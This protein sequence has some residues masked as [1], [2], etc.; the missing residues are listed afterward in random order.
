MTTWQA[1]F[2]RRPLQDELGNPLWELVVCTAD[3]SFT[4]SAFCP[5]PEANS[6]WISQ[7]LQRLIEGNINRSPTQIQVFRPQSVSLLQAACQPLNITVIPTRNTAALKALLQEKAELYRTLPH[8]TGQSYEPVA[9]E[10]P[11]PLPLPENLWGETWRFATI[12]AQDLVSAF[13][14]R[15]IPVLEMPEALLPVQLQLASTLPV[16]GVVI[17]G[18]RRSM[19]LARWMQRV[20]PFALE[21]IPGQPDG[22]IL[23]AGLVERWIL[24]TFVDPEVITAA[25]L[26]QSRQQQ[27]KGLH[28]LLIQPDDS[29]MTY[30]GLWLLQKNN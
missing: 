22:L 1:D 14:N 30:S 3:R 13:Q 6:A 26:F 24:T 20:K 23:E 21:Y 25:H 15:P 27:A 17:E 7:Q 29:G 2:Y 19:Q 8:Y 10:K 11:P 28:F 18:G 12:A 9:L 5:Q 16:P 4:A